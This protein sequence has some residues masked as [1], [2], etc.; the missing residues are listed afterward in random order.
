MGCSLEQIGKFVALTLKNPRLLFE[1]E[2]ND[3]LLADLEKCALDKSGRSNQPESQWY[4]IQKNSE[5]GNVNYWINND[6]KLKDLLCFLG[7]KTG[8]SSNN[9]Q[10]NPF[11]RYSLQNESIKKLLEI[12]PQGIPSK[13][14]RLREF[15]SDGKWREANEE[16]YLVMLKVADQEKQGYLNEASIEKFPCDD[17]R[18]SEQLWVNYSEGKFGFSVQKK[19]Y[20]SLGGTREYDH[21]VWKNFGVCVGWR[22][23]NAWLNYSDLTFDQ[24]AP[25]AHL[26]YG[27]TKIGEGENVRRRKSVLFSRAKTCNL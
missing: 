2:K 6:P 18:I 14:F 22:K 3:K 9:E 10:E 25:E 26:P 13:Y 11:R 16:T 20:E 15:L 4:P 5:K 1:L 19:I 7:H 23:E 27:T 12:S 17:R 21:E 8:E 24:N